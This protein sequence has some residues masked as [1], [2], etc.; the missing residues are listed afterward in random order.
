MSSTALAVFDN[1]AGEDRE[2]ELTMPE[3]IPLRYH[4]REAVVKYD[5][6]PVQHDKA[7]LISLEHPLFNEGSKSARF[8]W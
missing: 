1:R 6:L 4:Y 5:P 2:N 3:S 8:P 7:D